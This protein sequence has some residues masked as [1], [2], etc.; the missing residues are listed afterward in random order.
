LTLILYLLGVDILS[1]GLGDGEVSGKSK[2]RLAALGVGAKS[3]AQ[4]LGLAV[5]AK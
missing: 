1:V 3:A 5:I 2:T 4:T